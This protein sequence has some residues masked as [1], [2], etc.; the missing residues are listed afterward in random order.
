MSEPFT[1][2]NAAFQPLFGV[3][4][5]YKEGNQ[6]MSSQNGSSEQR[7]ISS[8]VREHN[9]MMNIDMPRDKLVVITGL[10][11]S[12]KSSLVLTPFMSATATLRWTAVRLRASFL[13]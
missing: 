2:Y 11:G 6:F 10:S 8:E 1:D 4:T 13:K 12:G 3:N 9:L 7:T 5:P